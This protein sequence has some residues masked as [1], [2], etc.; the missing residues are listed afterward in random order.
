MPE[1]VVGAH[2]RSRFRVE[3][4]GQTLA[5]FSEVS[6]L[7][8]EIEV[9]EYR[10]GTDPAHVTHKVPGRVKYSNIVLKR[11]VAKDDSLFKWFSQWMRAEPSA[12]RVTMRIVLLDNA[13]QEVRAWKV[14]NA[15]PAKYSGPSFDAASHDAAIETLE[16]A[17]EGI[18]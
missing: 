8:A 15:W 2:A 1:E 13:G 11:S 17:H 6:G 9:I 12:K 3:I 10:F 7:A 18:E 14:F 4:D 16:L 5:D